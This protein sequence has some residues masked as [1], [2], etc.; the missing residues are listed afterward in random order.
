MAKLKL[1]KFYNSGKNV[2]IAEYG[3]SETNHKYFSVTGSIGRKPGKGNKIQDPLYTDKGIYEYESGGC[4]HEQI[5]RHFPE[6]SDIV[7]LHLS[8][9]SGEPMYLIENGYYYYKAKHPNENTWFK[10]LQ[11]HLRIDKD[12]CQKL[13]SHLD[14]LET[15]QEKKSYFENYCISQKP[16]YNSEAAAIIAKYNLS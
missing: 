14:S 15:T 16:R 9:I 13:V 6:L 3:L 11:D 5:L 4:I 8:D 12:E 1:T 2:I 7:L 10:T